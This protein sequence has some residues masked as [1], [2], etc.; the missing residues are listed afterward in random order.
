MEAQFEKARAKGVR[1]RALEEKPELNFLESFFYSAYIALRECGP[2]DVLSFKILN[3]LS[4][5]E[6]DDV[7]SVTNFINGRQGKSNAN[8]KSRI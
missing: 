3:D 7:L 6:L 2:A 1:V 4:S 5:E 8:S